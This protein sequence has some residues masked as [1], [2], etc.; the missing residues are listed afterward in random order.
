M[1]WIPM[2]LSQS[3]SDMCIQSGE[4]FF[5]V[6]E[7]E[8][9]AY[10]L[11]SSSN[12]FLWWVFFKIGS[13]KLFAQAD[14]ELWSSWSLPPEYRGLQVW[15]HWLPAQNG[16]IFETSQIHIASGGQTKWHFALFLLLYY[17]QMPFPHFV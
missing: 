10:T 1:K 8:L 6:L 15:I 4:F 7:F 14:F 11:S 5:S 13:R 2:A 3:F 16:G 17:K 12:P 9:R